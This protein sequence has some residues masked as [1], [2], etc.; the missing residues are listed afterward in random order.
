MITLS[1][2]IAESFPSGPN[3]PVPVPVK[4]AIECHSNIHVTRSAFEL[5]PFCEI[6]GGN[7]AREIE[8]H[9]YFVQP[10]SEFREDKVRVQRPV[11]DLPVVVP[12]TGEVLGAGVGIERN[13]ADEI[14]AVKMQIPA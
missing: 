2:V 5:L 12:Q 1:K 8:I 11:D 10:V 9:C 3:R 7:R 13:A 4:L 14:G 6:D